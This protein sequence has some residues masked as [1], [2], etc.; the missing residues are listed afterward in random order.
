MP[1]RRDKDLGSHSSQVEEEEEV[2]EEDACPDLDA[3]YY[4]TDIEREMNR[5]EGLLWQ[6]DHESE[7]PQI[8]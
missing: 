4:G 5:S 8:T 2:E 1:T 7:I 3:K 6:A